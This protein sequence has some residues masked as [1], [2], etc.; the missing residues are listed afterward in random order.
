L[1]IA[2]ARKDG[3]IELVVLDSETGKTVA[4]RTL[5]GAELVSNIVLPTDDMMVVTVDNRTVTWLTEDNSLVDMPLRSFMTTM[6]DAD[7][8][9]LAVAGVQD[10]VIGRMDLESF[11]AIAPVDYGKVIAGGFLPERPIFWALSTLEGLRFWNTSEPQWSEILTTYF[12]EGQGFVTVNPQG[13]YDSNLGPDIGAFRWLVD[14]RPFQSLPQQTFMRDFYQPGLTEK[15]I[16]CS[17]FG[18]CELMLDPLPDVKQLTRATPEVRIV[19]VSAGENPAQAVVTVEIKEGLD[20]DA[21]PERQKSGVYNPRLFINNR[22]VD[23]HPTSLMTA[24]PELEIL[25]AVEDLEEQILALDSDNPENQG[26]QDN[27]FEAYEQALAKRSTIWQE[28]NLLKDEDDKPQDGIYNVAF[29]VDLPTLAGT[30]EMLISAYAFNKDRIKSETDVVSY[31]RDPVTPVKP[32]AFVI[33]IGIDAYVETR[34]NLSYAGADAKLF[35]ERL[36][37][38]PGYEMRRLMIAGEVGSDTKVTTS[39]INNILSLLAGLNRDDSLKQL[40]ALGVDASVLLESR[41]DDIII[42]SYSGHG[43]ASPSGNFYLVPNDAIWDSTSEKPVAPSLV[44]S[45]ELTGWLSFIRA[46]EIVLVIDACHSGASVDSGRFKP[47]PMGD[48]GLGQLAYDKGIRI[49]VATQAG[50]VAYENDKLK[51]GLLS[52]ALAAKGQALDNPDGLVDIDADRKLMLDEWLRYPTWSLLSA[53]G[54]EKE[55]KGEREVEGVEEGAFFFP[56]RELRK[57]EKVQLPSLFDFATPSTVVLKE[58][59]E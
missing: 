25:E 31:K 54:E 15:L 5:E 16:E 8:R 28:Q 57:E 47:G 12:F 45:Y 38:I 33:S 4:R 43:W 48:G 17:S 59:A 34:L 23:Q 10:D 46:A 9:I 11:E 44:S 22:L 18:D 55:A 24:L 37:D 19:D 58:I 20:K 41:P 32:R 14:D 35:N 56:N 49:L 36:A 6:V 7:E 29:T 13:R 26:E 30:E 1:G 50:D 39:A 42:I 52:Y 2:T 51:H 21:P 40:R 27:L 53:N 3:T